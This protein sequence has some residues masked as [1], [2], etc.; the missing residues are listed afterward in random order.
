MQIANATHRHP[1]RKPVPTNSRG[2]AESPRAVGPSV[3]PISPLDAAAAPGSSGATCGNVRPLG[4]EPRT[5]GVV[6]EHLAQ[7]TQVRRRRSENMACPRTCRRLHSRS[8]AVGPRVGPQ[9]MPPMTAQRVTVKA[10]D[11]TAASN[12]GRVIW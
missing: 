12:T 6:I 3:G 9:S 11:A 7:C 8:H 4:F 10:P 1:T 2:R 5:C